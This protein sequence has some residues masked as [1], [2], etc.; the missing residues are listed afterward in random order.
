ME[1]SILYAINGMHNAVLDKIMTV[2]TT[3]GDAGIIWIV[4]AIALLFNKKTR[5]CGILMAISMLLGIIFG[6]GLL[7]NLIARPRPFSVDETIELLIERP[8]DYS[9]PS[10]HTLASFEAAVTI[11]LHSKKWG[12]SAFI[13]AILIAFSRMYLF[14]H[15]PTD[16]LAGAIL[17]TLIAIIVF[18]GYEKYKKNKNQKLENEKA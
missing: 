3:L 14:V 9:F 10:G 1:L 17:G 2:I 4:I 12:I 11:F 16:V 8:T 15:Y 6:N 7:K 13:I 18:Y 5:K